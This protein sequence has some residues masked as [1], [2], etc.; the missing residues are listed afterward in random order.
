MSARR[1]GSNIEAVDLWGKLPVYQA[2]IVNSETSGV[3]VKSA[4][5]L[6]VG[7]RISFAAL[8]DLQGVDTSR[9]PPRNKWRSGVIWRID[10]G[11]LHLTRT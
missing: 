1:F 11:C 9:V 10:K 3:V 7:K 5:A 6:I 4:R 2:R 8:A